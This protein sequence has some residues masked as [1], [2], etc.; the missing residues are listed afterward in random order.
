MDL[1]LP[2]SGDLNHPKARLGQIVMQAFVGLIRGVAT[3]PFSLLAGVV[4]AEEDLSEVSFD[5]GQSV[6]GVEMLDRL[7]ALAV[8]LKAKPDLRLGVTASVTG[9]DVRVMAEARL[10]DRLGGRELE[11]SDAG[12][13]A[14]LLGLYREVVEGEPEGDLSGGSSLEARS[15]VLERVLEQMVAVEDLKRFADARVEAVREHLLVSQGLPEGRIVVEP[16]QLN[17]VRSGVMFDLR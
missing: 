7:N 15:V 2:L 3:A 1:S 11:L 5:R 9:E 12:F 14:Q 4:E 13:Y 8:A 6:L 16:H 10:R 17:G